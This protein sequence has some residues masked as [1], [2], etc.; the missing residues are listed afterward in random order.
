M[1]IIDA[2]EEAPPLVR[3]Q[4]GAALGLGVLFGLT[5]YKSEVIRW[6]RINKM[7]LFEEAHMYIIIAVAIAV[8]MPSVFL[9]RRFEART[10]TGEKLVLKDPPFQKGVVIGGLIFG[11]GWAIT[12]ACPGPIYAQIA[13]GE[14][15]A[16][17]TLTGA[18]VGMYIYARLRPRLPH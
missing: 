14:L 6:E 11:V 13:S 16:I 7:F 5:L 15:A 10:V 3:W 4:Y 9:I 18:M 12:A 17:G 2:P 1:D 8:A